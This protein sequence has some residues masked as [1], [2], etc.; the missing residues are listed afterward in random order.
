M[1]TV[2]T[3]SD[4]ELTSATRASDSSAE[5]GLTLAT[6]TGAVLGAVAG[7]VLGAEFGSAF[8]ALGG[9]LGTMLGGCSLAGGWCAFERVRAG[10]F[11]RNTRAGSNVP[12]EESVECA[13]PLPHLA[14]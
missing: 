14:R 7:T 2:E 13:H 10:L 5:Q 8:P 4:R 6:M 3:F 11:A 1:A 12:R 9:T